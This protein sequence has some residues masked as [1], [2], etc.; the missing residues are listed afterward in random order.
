MD[1]FKVHEQVI[2]DYRTFTSGFV[3]V[4]DQRIA[5][6]VDQQFAD[7]VQWPDPWLSLNPS[8]ATGGSIP[9]QVSAGVLDEECARIFRR[10]GG[11][12][13]PGREPIGCTSTSGRPSRSPG[14][15]RATS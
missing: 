15:A 1:G 12:N 5:D 6:F 9:E 14:R 8:F 10:K 4:R 7:G 11:P 3:E 2:D 13:D